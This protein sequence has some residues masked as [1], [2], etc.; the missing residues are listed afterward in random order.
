MDHL[1][2]N[3]AR[4]YIADADTELEHIA[5]RAP[6]P[7]LVAEA[8]FNTRRGGYPPWAFIAVC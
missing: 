2:G 6:G 5:D 8:R 3:R 4:Q 1:R 7:D